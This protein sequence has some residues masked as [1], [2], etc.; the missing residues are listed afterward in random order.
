M[1]PRQRDQGGA[2]SASGQD[3]GEQLPW[4]I[5][6]YQAPDGATPALEFLDRCPGTLDAQFTAVLDAVAAAPPPRFSGGGKWEAMHGTMGGWYEIRLTGPGREQFRLFCLLENGT[7]GEL[8]RRG[9]PRPVIAVITGLRKPWRTVFSECDYQ[10][11]RELGNE[12]RRNYPRR[13]A[14]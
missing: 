10:R 9:F 12:H 14:T 3:H 6:Y 8:A 1:P 13:I 4:V 7:D 2:R 5:V 11:V